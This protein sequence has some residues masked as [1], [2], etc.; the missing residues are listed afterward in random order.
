MQKQRCPSD[1]ATVD[2]IFRKKKLTSK[3]I[4]QQAA[5]GH[6]INT[7]GKRTTDPFILDLNTRWI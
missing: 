3:T 4:M 7:H 1:A 2:K 5:P 6:T